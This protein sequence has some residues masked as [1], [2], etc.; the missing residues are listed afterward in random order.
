[1]SQSKTTGVS[2]DFLYGLAPNDPKYQCQIRGS[3]NKGTVVQR[4]IGIWG[5]IFF[6]GTGVLSSQPLGYFPLSE[7]GRSTDISQL[8][9]LELHSPQFQSQDLE[10]LPPLPQLEFLSLGKTQIQSLNRL[11]RKDYPK[12]AVLYLHDTPVNDK[13]FLTWKDPPVITKLYV[14]RTQITSLEWVARFPKLRQLNL[15]STSVSSLTPIADSRELVELWIGRTKVT[16][17][18][19]IYGLTTLTYLGIDFLPIP[20]NERKM[21][22]KLSPYTKLVDFS[23]GPEKTQ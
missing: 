13:T 18:E 20:A 7:L 3:C 9:H 23:F 12:L 15:E 11:N 4:R 6:L 21:F 8:R 22:R 14:N 10:R 2:R 16:S 5:T 1:M 19:P 17:L